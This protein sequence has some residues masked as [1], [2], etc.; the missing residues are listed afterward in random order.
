M[1]VLRSKKSEL[2]RPVYVA[3]ILASVAFLGL[4][5]ARLVDSSATLSVAVTIAVFVLL[6]GLVRVL[7]WWFTAGRTRVSVS[8]EALLVRGRLRT[9]R[10]QPQ[11]VASAY[12]LPGEWRPE[13]S[14]WAV[15]PRVVL[16]LRDGRQ[17]SRQVLLDSNGVLREGPKLHSAV[18]EAAGQSNQDHGMTG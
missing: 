12:I 16:E 4:L 17:I 6:V 3:G 10:L 14:R 15:H 13:W 1:Y 11:D 7:N 5:A 8:R 9:V 2:W 18:V